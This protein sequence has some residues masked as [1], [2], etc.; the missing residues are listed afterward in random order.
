M[1]IFWLIGLV[2]LYAVCRWYGKFKGR[3]AQE[4]LWRFF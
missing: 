4:S 1:Y 2:L 3:K